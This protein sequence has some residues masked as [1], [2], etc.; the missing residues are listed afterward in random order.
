MHLDMH[1]TFSKDRLYFQKF[2]KGN[3]HKHK[4]MRAYT[5]KGAGRD[6]ISKLLS[7]VC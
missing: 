7:L 2:V 5:E 6:V 1:T 3:T 4:C